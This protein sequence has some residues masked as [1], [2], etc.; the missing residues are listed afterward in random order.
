MQLTT[1]QVMS[2]L[3]RDARAS[4]H[5]RYLRFFDKADITVDCWPGRT[6]LGGHVFGW[7]INGERGT[8]QQARAVIES[9]RA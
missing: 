5:G 2:V 8:E 1:D 9:A 6:G 7:V 4:G 3:Q